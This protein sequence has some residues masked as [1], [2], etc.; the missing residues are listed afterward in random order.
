[1]NAASEAT[2]PTLIG[3]EKPTPRLPSDTRTSG[4]RPRRRTAPST[5]SYR[6]GYLDSFARTGGLDH[7]RVC[8]HGD[9]PVF[10]SGDEA[11][12][13]LTRGSGLVNEAV[14]DARDAD[15]S[16]SM[17][18]TRLTRKRPRGAPYARRQLLLGARAHRVK[19]GSSLVRCASFRPGRPEEKDRL[20]VGCVQSDLR[21]K[22][23][24]GWQ[25]FLEVRAY[26][27][28]VSW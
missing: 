8:K 26:R 1:M 3:R 16:G 4:R 2:T 6:G 19:P 25:S 23:S 27:L 24:F 13:S 15:P 12:V 11:D 7:L 5:R 9:L 20:A 22:R 17:E 14:V 21:R 18:Q 10:E 28:A